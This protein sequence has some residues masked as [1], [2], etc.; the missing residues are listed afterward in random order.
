[1]K[2]DSRYLNNKKPHREAF[3]LLDVLSFSQYNPSNQLFQER[4]MTT[5]VSEKEIPWHEAPKGTTHYAPETDDN[6]ATE[7]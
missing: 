1:M 3:L 7:E 4:I 2:Q 6:F 5:M